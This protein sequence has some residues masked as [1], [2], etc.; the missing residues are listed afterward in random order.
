[1]SGHH[2]SGRFTLTIKEAAAAADVS[3]RTI[4]NWIEEGKIDWIRV[5]SGKIRI[6]EDSL[7]KDVQQRPTDI[8]GLT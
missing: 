4:Y 1:M 7:W 2:P 6:F 3:R 5:P 8:G